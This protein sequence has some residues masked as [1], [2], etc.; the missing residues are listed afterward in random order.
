MSPQFKDWITVSMS[1]NDTFRTQFD[2]TETY[3]PSEA[4][5]AQAHLNDPGIYWQAAQNPEEYWAEQAQHLS[6][7]KPFTEIL[8]WSHPPFAKWFQ[9]GELNVAVNCLDRHVD[10]GNG[11]RIAYYF[12]GEPGDS[13]AI[14]YT[15][16]TSEVK[17]AANM[18][19][20]LGVKAGDRVVIYMPL[21]PEAVIAMLAVA[22]LGATHSVVFGGFSAESLR[23][24]IDD[25]QAE[26]V[27]TADGGYRKG[28]VSALKPTVD[29]ALNLTTE[30]E[31]PVKKVLVV[32]RGKNEISMEPG[33]DLWWHEEIT[34]FDDE[35]VAQGF[36]AENPLFI[37][38]T[39]GTT[40]RPKG[41][42][43]VLADT[44]HRLPPHT[45]MFSI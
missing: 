25:A 21:I 30:T 5:Q 33:R 35:H 20:S 9:D 19:T 2:E 31:L 4:F 3:P 18:L 12:E 7:S 40:G 8:D 34:S 45:E 17:R 44:S 26:M 24:R 38:Y 1:E 41:I 42:V 43:T 36:P 23:S 14:T 32:E 22:R 11:D 15:E 29:A 10:A 39:S 13:R 16:L 6:W 28:R 37:L 27:I